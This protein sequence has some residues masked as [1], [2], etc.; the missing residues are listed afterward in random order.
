MNFTKS[1]LFV[2]L[3]VS[4]IFAGDYF[5]QAVSYK[6]NA[7][8]YPDNHLLT[9]KSEMIYT[10]NSPDTLNEIYL[11]LHWNI[12]QENSY[13]R[14]VNI[15]G[16]AI[17]SPVT[18][19]TEIKSVT[20][21]NKPV[22]DICE[23]DNTIMKIPLHKKL[24]PGKSITIA[25]DAE[26][27]VPSTRLRM[28]RWGRDYCVAHW[29]PA[30][31][32]YD[33]QGWQID[34]YLGEGE[35][36]EEIGNYNVNLTIP[37]SF[38]VF[39]S[40]ELLNA[41]EVLP[42]S[43]IQNL[44]S[45][46]S[47]GKLTRIFRQEEIISDENSESTKL[48]KFQA[49][50]V[51]T[52]AFAAF[53]NRIWDACF[54]N[55]VMV[56]TV[57][58]PYNEEYYQTEGM[59]ASLHA[60]NYLSD[61]FGKYP[62]KN[63]FVVGAKNMGGGMEY[64]GITFVTGTEV[65][66]TFYR[67]QSMVLIHEII[68]NWCP[69]TIN[70]NETKYAFMDEGFT[71]YWTLKAM[72]NLYGEDF[73]FLS[74]PDFLN[75]I[76]PPLGMYNTYYNSVITNGLSGLSEPVLTHSDRYKSS[77]NYNL[78]SYQK[79]CMVIGML[80]YVIGEEAFAELF[81]QYFTRFRFKHVYPNDFFDLAEEINYK[82][83]HSR[84][85]SWFFD[86]WLSKTYL[87]DYALKDIDYNYENG[88]GKYNTTI[89]I[90]RLEDAIMPCDVE[91]KLEDGTSTT[92]KF[93]AADFFKGPSVVSK[94]FEFNS[95][96]LCAEI[97]PKV[98]LLDINRLN[99]FSSIIPP[100]SF[101]LN[102]LL[103]MSEYMNP[104]EYSVFWFPAFGFNNIDGFKL[105]LNLKGTYLGIGKNFELNLLQGM[106]FGK[107]SF[108][109]DIFIEDN[110]KLFGPMAKGSAYYFNYEGRRGGNIS[111]SK[112][113][114]GYSDYPL[115]QLDF[116]ANYFD[117]YDDAYF[118]SLS[119]DKFEGTEAERIKQRKY[120]WINTGVTYHNA[121]LYLRFNSKINF[122]SGFTYIN[123]SRR[124]AFQKLTFE[125]SENI[126]LP[127]FRGLKLRQYF[128][129]SPNQLPQAKSYYLA[130]VNPVEEFSSLIYRTPGIISNS[131]RTKRSI[132]NGGGYMRGYYNQNNFGDIITT[133]NAELN[134]SFLLKY[135]PVVG[136]FFSHVTWLFADA[137]NV[138]NSLDDMKFKGLLY[139]YGF[140]IKLPLKANIISYTSTNPFAFLTK[141]G[142]NSINFDFPLYVSNPPAGEKKFQFRWLFGFQC[143]L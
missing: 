135:I 49:D 28:G 15:S 84:D 51:R 36:N 90:E 33:K 110:V 131:L 5:Q 19:G 104:N 101:H 8:L 37:S 137:G 23:I 6:I 13:A 142:I 56:N 35:F 132:P 69:M 120:I 78:N 73:S 46:K 115:N 14:Q 118:N 54:N 70:S 82:Y 88:S 44:R 24:A 26:E 61:N 20:M 111:F 133:L 25:I 141:L 140:S 40:G 95:K 72:E 62:Y 143:P 22:T 2:L 39:H 109:G 99:N 67:I 98:L 103:D 94:T 121:N 59:K 85:L 86:E 41:E 18:K 96:P 124:D 27:E 81:H 79:T 52:F 63:V 129:Y 21:N 4:N 93:D 17:Y 7:E 11:R 107:N 77:E 80:R 3:I 106:K 117:A 108:G 43:A 65:Y 58:F 105:G 136:G 112:V 50:S 102:T 122:E 32:V 139:D 60:V 100:V 134:A 114:K 97:D 127:F 74:L 71:D 123:S 138:W 128:G 119:F 87:F 76:V 75:S 64:P 29:F 47:T 30:V 48:W 57:Y 91:V 55:G 45:A 130:T 83:N 12:F 10:N 125:L 66:K 68:H 42:D 1:L 116:S 16:R 126:W 34:Q 113:F 89:A 92:V 9:L 38:L 31:C 53:E